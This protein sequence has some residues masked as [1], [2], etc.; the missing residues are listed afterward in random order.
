M[1]VAL[2]LASLAK[3]QGV[4]YHTARRTP[5]PQQGCNPRCYQGLDAKREDQHRSKAARKSRSPAITAPLPSSASTSPTLPH[6]PA[7]ASSPTAGA[8]PSWSAGRGSRRQQGRPEGWQD[9]PSLVHAQPLTQASLPSSESPAESPVSRQARN[10]PWVGAP[11]SCGHLP[12]SNLGRVHCAPTARAWR[13]PIP[14]TKR[15]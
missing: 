15:P 12:G 6:S 2:H 5:R 9:R 14:S 4:R 7:C 3:S 8:P 11:L 13:G 10:L 1:A